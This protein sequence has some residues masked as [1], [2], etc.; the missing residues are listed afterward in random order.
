[1]CPMGTNFYIVNSY[2]KDRASRQE[3]LRQRSSTSRMG[4]NED[5][6]LVLEDA[7]VDPV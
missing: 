2:K 5:M 4:S 3:T 7:E 1:M 6:H